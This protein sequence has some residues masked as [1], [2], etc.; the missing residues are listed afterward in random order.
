V[1]SHL[2]VSGIFEYLNVRLRRTFQQVTFA[3]ADGTEGPPSSFAQ[4]VL[5]LFE[6]LLDRVQVDENILFTTGSLGKSSERP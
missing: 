5:E 1:E 2:V 6:D 4:P 3:V